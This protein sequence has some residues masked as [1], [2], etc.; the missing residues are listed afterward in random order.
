MQTSKTLTRKMLKVRSHK[1]KFLKLLKRY[2][3]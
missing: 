2:T 3:D 1:E